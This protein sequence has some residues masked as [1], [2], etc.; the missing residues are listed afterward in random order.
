MPSLQFN[1]SE[2]VQSAEHGLK[3]TTGFLNVENYK[4]LVQWIK[5]IVQVLA[6]R[7]TREQ[8]RE[9]AQLLASIGQDVEDLA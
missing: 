8:D 7:L 4:P 1:P 2:P 6:G 3:A 5:T 9:A